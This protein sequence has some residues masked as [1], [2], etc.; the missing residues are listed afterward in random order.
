MTGEGRDLPMGRGREQAPMR[1]L[2]V[3]NSLANGGLERQLSLLARTLPSQFDVRIWAMDGGPHEAPLRAANVP[4]IVRP[5]RFRV[6]VTPALDLW[7][8]I[9]AWRPHVV[10]SWHWMPSAAAV[11]ACLALGIPLVDGSIRMGSIPHE[12]GRPRRG[13]MRFATLVVANSRAGLNAWR[14]SSEK[15]RV[16]YNA[17][18][19]ERLTTVPSEDPHRHLDDRFTVVMAARMDPPKD[20]RTVL[21]AARALHAVDPHG[22]RFVLIGAGADR[23]SIIDEAEDLV[24]A[25]LVEFP[26]LGTEVVGYL[27]ESDVGVLM[28]DPSVLA[29]GCPNSVMEYMA[30][31]L[32]VICA[33]S[34]GCREVLGGDAGIVVP[35]KD[36]TALGS[37][38]TFLRDREDVRE[39]MEIA[40]RARVATAFTVARMA[41]EFAALYV[42]AAARGR[43]ER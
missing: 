36:A 12:R 10:H 31:G 11:P 25:G 20:F 2:L 7:R 43:G 33:N 42:E 9:A 34:G 15:G 35:P 1:V 23:K 24:R 21:R 8:C 40:G 32:P 29:E 5:R 18:E 30:C 39:R 27:R 4:L 26:E 17:F 16:I 3:T 14:V 13:I 28:S 22:W 41:Q 19:A 6:D 38:L 37:A